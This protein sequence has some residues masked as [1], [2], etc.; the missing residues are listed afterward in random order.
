MH[1]QLGAPRKALLK[2]AEEAAELVL[3]PRR[4]KAPPEV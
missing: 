2:D 4:G 3:L 1:A